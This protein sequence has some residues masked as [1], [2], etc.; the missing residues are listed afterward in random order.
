MSLYNIDKTLLHPI[1]I[2]YL[3]IN[4]L[5]DSIVS[6]NINS[7][8]NSSINSKISYCELSSEGEQLFKM[9]SY[10]YYNLNNGAILVFKRWFININNPEGQYSIFNKWKQQY[11]DIKINILNSSLD[12][13]GNILKTFIF[14]RDINQYTGWSD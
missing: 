7:T 11:R 12:H 3:N 2:T 4:K 6:E 14:S 10:L 1:I 5:N 9:L 13:N 8:I